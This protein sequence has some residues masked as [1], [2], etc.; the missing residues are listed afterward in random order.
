MTDVSPMSARARLRRM[1]TW[2]RAVKLFQDFRVEQTDPDRFYGTM[3]ADSVAQLACL[4]DLRGAHVLDVG[5]GPGYWAEEFE[6]AGAAYTP[7][8]ADVGELALHGRVPLPGTV[9]GDGQALPFRDE[10]FDL[11][12]SSNVAEHVPDPWRMG[13][14]MVRV[15]RPGGLIFYSYTLWYGPWGG[16]ETAPWHF[17]NGRFAAERYTRRTGHPPKNVYG[18]SLFPVTMA[19]GIRWARAHA[20]AEVVDVI[21]RYLPAGLYWIGRVPVMREFI[22]WNVALILRKR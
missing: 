10:A 20:D 12:Y 1:A 11:V 7:L 9:I 5:G 14:E 17:V 16:H 19:A 6:R 4:A 8:D 3:A 21:P 22:T 18:E 13:D 15:C 2:S